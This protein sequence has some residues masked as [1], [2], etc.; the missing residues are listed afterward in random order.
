MLS[1]FNVLNSA[2]LRVKKNN[3]RVYAIT[4]NPVSLD[5]TVSKASC[6]TAGNDIY[7]C[8]DTKLFKSSDG[9]SN[10]TVIT[11]L[12][13]SLSFTNFNSVSSNGTY[14][15]VGTNPAN[16]SYSG[17][18]ISTDGGNTWNLKLLDRAVIYPKGIMINSNKLFMGV[19]SSLSTD[20]GY[21]Y[22][23]L[24]NTTLT[25][26]S[27]TT[28]NTVINSTLCLCGNDDMTLLYAGSSGG[29]IHKITWTGDVPLVEDGVIV[30]PGVS[31]SVRAIA[32][33]SDCSIIYCC[34]ISNT[35]SPN[36]RVYKS[37]NLGV[38]YSI[39]PNS[40]ISTNSLNHW[41]SLCCSSDGNIV[42]GCISNQGIYA[43][44]DS[45]NTW[46]SYLTSTNPWVDLSITND[47][48]KFVA[49]GDTT[50][51]GTLW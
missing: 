19:F 7:V 8:Y 25:R 16:T 50:Y 39:L 32:C 27:K 29:K 20:T 44:L 46:I 12:Y 40:P 26:I 22:T 36:G 18:R 48:T 3:N 1:S 33:S 38:S 14:I 11:N 43:S 42:V 51:I 28:N 24:P 45:G 5:T 30:V 17:M 15:A 34:P 9:G 41:R 2:N 23:Y 4:L 37:T 10:W 47:G 31:L 35:A 6:I 21:H 13:D 49:C